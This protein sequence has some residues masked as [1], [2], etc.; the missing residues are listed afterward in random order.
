M[1]DSQPDAARPQPAAEPPYSALA[2]G[3]D[4]VMA[5]VDYDFWA[6]YAHGRLQ[7]HHPEA[8]S[9]FELACGTG[10]LALA[11]QPLGPYDYAATDAAPEM[12]RVARR[13]AEHAGS[14]V[15]FEVADFREARPEAPV[16]AVVLL[17][18]G[19]NYLHAAGD[20]GRLLRAA[21]A[22]LRP[23]G[24]FLFDQSTPANSLNNQEFFEDEGAAEGFAYV[25]RSRYDAD[26]RLHTTSFELTV[27][28]RRYR[29]E[30][31]QRAYTIAEIRALLDATPFTVEAAY[32][33]FTT[34]T[35]TAASERV[36]WVV[37]RGPA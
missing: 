1:P 29:E 15:R 37:R 30:H 19:L 26:T 18:D 20:V 33:G 36:H 8:R 2:A 4:L 23:G 14:P 17:Y 6:G 35:A 25:R 3:Y 11:L 34:A 5:H 16:D 12:I 22:A 10:S 13:K 9:V 31:V 28:G 24:V 7:E 32:D 21:H 27:A